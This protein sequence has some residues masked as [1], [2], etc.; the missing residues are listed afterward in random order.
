MQ[1]NNRKMINGKSIIL[2]TC[3]Y[4]EQWDKKLW[5]ED[6]DRMLAAG[7]QVVRVAEFAWNKFEP[8]E[9][10]YDFTFF[11]EFL[12]LAEEKEIGRAHV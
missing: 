10:E 8:R 2:G 11:D 6:F 9:G 4:P 7:I 1:Q 3:Y 12:K 5:A